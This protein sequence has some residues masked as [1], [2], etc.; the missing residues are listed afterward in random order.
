MGFYIETDIAE[1]LMVKHIAATLET[2]LLK[3]KLNHYSLNTWVSIANQLVISANFF[4]LQLWT[5][6]VEQLEKMDNEVANFIWSG[7]D[8]N[9]RH[10][11]SYD[12]ITK[13]KVEGG[14]GLI[15]FK[16]QTMAQAGKTIL[17]VGSNGEETL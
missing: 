13:S 15:S 1:D 3:A 5:G 7:S 17:W 4:M 11:M 16:T 10:R 14:L 8:G 9:F 12:I 2:R 6:N